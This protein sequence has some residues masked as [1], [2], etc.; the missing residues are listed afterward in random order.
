MVENKQNIV[1][2]QH[3]IPRALLC[4]FANS[5]NKLFEVLLATKKVYSTNP[6]D[7]MS[8]RFIYEDDNLKTNTVENFFGKIETEVVPLVKALIE[9]VEKYKKGEASFLEI[10]NLIEDLLPTFIVFYYRSGA[11]L[12]EFSSL[13]SK[14]KIP[15]LSKKILNK[16]Y[17]QLLAETVKRCY[18]FAIIESDADFLMSDQFLSTAGLKIKSNFT[19]V[20]N[21]H[22]GMRE[23]LILI[24]ISS[25]YYA[26]YWHSDDRFFLKEDSVNTLSGDDL[27]LVNQVIIN[28]SYIKCIS[29]KEGNLKAVLD[30]YHMEFP[31]QVF[32]GYQSGYTSG[33]IRKK[34]V[35]FYDIDK[36]AFDM[37]TFHIELPKYLKAERND[38][39]PCNSGK[40][41][42][43]C[44]LDIYERMKVPWQNIMNQES[45]K[46]DIYSIPNALCVELPIDQWG[47]YAKEQK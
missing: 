2:N 22:I 19:N 38:K 25:K 12:T 29:G 39:C 44:H 8:A 17:I 34:E 47:G 18:K 36:K 45:I 31:S 40:K 4:N 28:N 23:T 26:V 37:M 21:R 32:M 27:K 20:S 7:S 6:T 9:T 42:K 46:G 33:A 41:F 24:P 35:F 43:K 13:G 3:Y 10:K 11:L 30:D 5:K 1:E 15:L 14:D 16:P